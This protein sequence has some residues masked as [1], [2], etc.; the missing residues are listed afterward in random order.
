V[1]AGGGGRGRAGAAVLREFADYCCV[2][3]TTDCIS[4]ES[5]KFPGKQTE[6]YS[7]AY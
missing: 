3:H 1:G 7:P 4:K 2:H 5:T 6:L